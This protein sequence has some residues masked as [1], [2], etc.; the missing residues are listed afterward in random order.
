MRAKTIVDLLSL[1][2]SLYMLSK[3]HDFLKKSAE[4]TAE[5]KNNAEEDYDAEGIDDH[6]STFVSGILQN[7][8]LMKEGLEQKL[9]EVASK[10]YEKM[11]I[12]HT[13]EIRKLSEEIDLLRTELALT[14][15]KVVNL[16]QKNG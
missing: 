9:N 1:S 4:R 11:H 5:S 6:E 13:D 10:V 3:E 7:A 14:E 16:Q 12:A 2:V 15:A 8:A